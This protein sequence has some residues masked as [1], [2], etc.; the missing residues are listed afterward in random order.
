MFPE[1]GGRGSCCGCCGYGFGGDCEGR[2]GVLFGIVC[3][4]CSFDGCGIVVVVNSGDDDATA[5]D[6]ADDCG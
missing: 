1:I 3:D 4:V 5:D 2:L 6:D